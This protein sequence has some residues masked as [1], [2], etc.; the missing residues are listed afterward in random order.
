MYPWPKNLPPSIFDGLGIES[1]S[2]TVNTVSIHFQENISIIIESGASLI[3]DDGVDVLTVPSLKTGIVSLVGNIVLR[4]TID[5][6][7]SSLVLQFN[8]GHTLKILGGNEHYECFHVI[9]GS[10]EYTI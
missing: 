3:S 9:V 8:S 6:D 5:S 4:G 7:G 2:F 10:A 1:I